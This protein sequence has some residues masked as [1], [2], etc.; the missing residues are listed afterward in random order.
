[1]ASV[2]FT[3]CSSLLPT[4]TTGSLTSN[5]LTPVDLQNLPFS[6]VTNSELCSIHATNIPLLDLS[7]CFSNLN[8]LPDHFELAHSVYDLEL[9]KSLGSN[10]SSCEYTTPDEFQGVH[11]EQNS[12]SLLQR[13]PTFFDPR[14]TFF[15]TP[16]SRT[17]KNETSRNGN[18]IPETAHDVV[19]T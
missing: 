12:F 8:S 10:F 7:S 14:T 13:F 16:C 1:M 18:G 15:Q 11:V 17:T 5:S 4:T 19:I 3:S 2:D 9:F 6:S